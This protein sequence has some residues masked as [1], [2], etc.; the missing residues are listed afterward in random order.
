M[1][2]NYFFIVRY[3]SSDWET[4]KESCQMLDQFGIPY[5]KKV[6]S[7]HRTPQLMFEFSNEARANGYDAS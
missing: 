7:A 6:V 3:C 1:C 5:D 4:M 2:G